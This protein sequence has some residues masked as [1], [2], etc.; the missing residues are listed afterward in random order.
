MARPA[1]AA[2]AG[3]AGGQRDDPQ[4]RERRGIIHGPGGAERLPVRFG[5]RQVHHH[6]AGGAHHHASQQHR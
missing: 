6:P 5:I 4:L 2:R 3:R 1:R